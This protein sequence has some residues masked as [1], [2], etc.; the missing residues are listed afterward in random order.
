MSALRGT[1]SQKAAK[2]ARNRELGRIHILKAELNLDR[3]QYEEV[4]W[5]VARVESA[6]NLDDYGRREVIKHLEAHAK[7]KRGV[8][9]YPGRPANADANQRTQLRKIEAYLTDAGRP[10]EYGLSMAWRMY[11][12]ERLEFC[13]EHELAGIIAALEADA[14]KRLT[15]ALLAE[16]GEEWAEW[17]QIHA[18]VLFGF[19]R[20]RDIA[21]S[22]HDMS[23]VWRWW[24][25][26]VTVSC[27]WPVHD[28]ATGLCEGCV[29]RARAQRSVHSVEAAS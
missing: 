11:K 4:L 19:S 18:Q 27:A 29:Q 13:G 12:R 15:A 22:A 2:Q 7:A 6:A 24:K 21:K 23:L 25:G 16:F 5:A 8:K 9:T 3:D 20:G 10:W 14:R 17:A 1:A 26:S 28:N